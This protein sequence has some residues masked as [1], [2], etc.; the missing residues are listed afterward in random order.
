MRL[1]HWK[2]PTSNPVFMKKSKGNEL[3]LPIL[4]T[5]LEQLMKEREQAGF[6][7]K[8]APHNHLQ[9]PWLVSVQKLLC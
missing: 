3:T 1:I 4:G 9:C 2:W 8:R 5:I 6:Y 7:R